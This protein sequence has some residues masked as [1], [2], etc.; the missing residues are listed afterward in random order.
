[1]R[2]KVSHTTRYRFASNAGYGLQQLR[3]TPKSR[4]EQK[5]LD[6]QISLQGATRQAQFEDQHNNTVILASIEEGTSEIVI[7]SSG[8]VETTATSGVIGQHGGFAP[9]WYFLRSTP[10]TKSG[11][12]VRELLSALGTGHGDDLSKMH[13]LST[14]IAKA[15][16]YEVGTTDAETTAEQALKSGEGVCQD[17][18][19]IFITATRKLGF[20]SR[21]VSGYLMMND[22]VEQEAGHA[23]AEVYLEPLGWVGFD[24]SNGI[25]P[26]ERYVRVATGLD[27][28]EAAPVSGLQFKNAGSNP[29]ENGDSGD[30]V[31]VNVS[32]QQ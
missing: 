26:D 27:Y 3:V 6:W 13:A 9:L 20:P 23:W 21:Y 25:S 8:E 15:V 12:G 18:A 30:S 16:N 2:L 14:K 7:K 24:V 11:E 1:M 17:H 31:L 19:H 5:V 29:P 28:A 10:T 4:K 22:R 32:V